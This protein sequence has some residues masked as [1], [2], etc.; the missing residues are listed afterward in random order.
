MR[1]PQRSQNM[2][3]FD[4]EEPQGEAKDNSS[5][6]SRDCGARGDTTNWSGRLHVQTVLLG[7]ETIWQGLELQLKEDKAPPSPQDEEKNK[8]G[9]NVRSAQDDI[10]AE[11]EEERETAGRRQGAIQGPPAIERRIIAGPHMV[12]QGKVPATVAQGQAP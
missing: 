6:L 4:F 10:A 11:S 3:L 9:A 1:K 2:S 12:A 7:Q 5:Q 8:V